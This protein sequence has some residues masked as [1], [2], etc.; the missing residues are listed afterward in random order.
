MLAALIA[1]TAYP[2]RAFSQSANDQPATLSAQRSDTQTT[3][4]FVIPPSYLSTLKL[5]AAP[6]P[7]AAAPPPVYGVSYS[8]TSELLERITGESVRPIA[9]VA[10]QP[11]QYYEYVPAVSPQPMVRRPVLEGFTEK[12]GKYKL[13]DISAKEPAGL[14]NKLLELQERDL[15]DRSSFEPPGAPPP[16]NTF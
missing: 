7:A 9:R 10:P 3:T 14:N 6:P 16:A 4:I 13:R 8:P 12:N 2:L 15:I 11:V 1:I 5:G